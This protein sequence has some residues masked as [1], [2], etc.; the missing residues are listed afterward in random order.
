MPPQNGCDKPRRI[1]VDEKAVSAPPVPLSKGEF[2]V[3]SKFPIP[4]MTLEACL[5]YANFWYAQTQVQALIG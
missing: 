3:S 5:A 2:Q 1:T 4:P